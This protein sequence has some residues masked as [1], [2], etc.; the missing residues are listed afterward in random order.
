MSG[1]CNEA[2][3]GEASLG[4]TRQRERI[5][6]TKADVLAL[7]KRDRFESVRGAC[8]RIYILTCKMK[9]IKRNI[10]KSNLD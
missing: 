3:C 7:V 9:F 1:Y 8:D 4:Y 5:N 2:R 6:L 10:T